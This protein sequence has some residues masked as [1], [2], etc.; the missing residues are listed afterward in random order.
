MKDLVLFLVFIVLWGSGFAQQQHMEWSKDT[1]LSWNDFKGTP[2]AS[3][4]FLAVTHAGFGYK[5][6]ANQDSIHVETST[7]FKPLSSWVKRPSE[8]LLL[9]E[10]LH[11]DIAEY[12]RRVFVN[13]LSK[14]TVAFGTAK[15]FIPELYAQTLAEL[16]KEQL[17]YDEETNHSV[18]K[19]KQEA[20][21]RKYYE[22]LKDSFESR[23]VHISFTK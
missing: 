8:H 7:H 23:S 11:F 10:Q 17:R 5:Y 12:F 1:R 16:R 14:S 3:N 19:E 4:P 21:R 9:H 13:K 22:K 15:Q 6:N 2:D 18:N 20:W